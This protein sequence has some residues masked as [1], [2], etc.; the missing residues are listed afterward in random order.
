MIIV[1]ALSVTAVASAADDTGGARV[2]F[3]AGEPDASGHFQ[4]T[5][6]IYNAKFN[7][8]QFVMRYDKATVVPVNSKGE[9]T[10]SFSAFASKAGDADWLATVGTSI[11]GEKGLIDFT[12]YVSAGTSVNT[13]GLAEVSG[14]ANV[15][16]SGVHVF[17]FHFKKVGDKNIVIEIAKQDST[18]PYSRFLPA[19][20]ALLDAGDHIQATVTFDLPASVGKSH[21]ETSSPLPPAETMT[22]AERLKGTIALQIG[23]YGATAEGALIHIDSDNKAV[24]PY[25]DDNGR[26]MVP[27]RFIAE[28]LGASVAWDPVL[29]KVTITHEGKVIIMNIGSTQYFVNGEKKA[30]DTAPAIKAGW[31]RT[32]VPIRFVA[33]ALGMSVG[34]DPTNKLVLIAPADKP[35]QPDKQAEKDAVSD[36]LLVISPVF[37]DFIN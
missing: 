18:K 21:S 29:R 37:R 24:V 5:M 36:I 22:K 9:V 31:N 16:K 7:T 34:W 25:I 19:G 2:V 14:Y 27:V 3:K 15:G 23:N 10:S 33:E 4:V 11:D 32:M 1:L 12:G 30:M 17:N 6:T 26:T 20:G 13:D 28:K 35:W 8:F